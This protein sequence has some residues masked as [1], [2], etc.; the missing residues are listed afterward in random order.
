VKTPLSSFSPGDVIAGRC[1]RDARNARATRSLCPSRLRAFSMFSI[2]LDGKSGAV[3][4]NL[5][6]NDGVLL[7]HRMNPICTGMPFFISKKRVY[8]ET[9]RDVLRATISEF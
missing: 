9:Q 5:C 1:L 6:K 3:R 2:L 4:K 7:V 8:L